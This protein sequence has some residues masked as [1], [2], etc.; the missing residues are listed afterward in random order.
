M[1]QN[2]GSAEYR[3]EADT[4]D[5]IKNM[6]A[7]VAATKGM[8]SEF[9]KADRDLKSF[10][11]SI[12]SM[13]NRVTQS[14]KVINAFGTENKKLT[15]ELKKLQ[16]Q[17]E[18]AKSRGI[19][20]LTQ[21]QTKA[22]PQVNKLT[23]AFRVQRGATQQLSFQLQDIAVQAQQGTNAFTILGQQ[24]SQVA[25][26]L[27]PGGA[28]IGALI[29][30]GALI[31]SVLSSGIEE[32][33]ESI[34]DLI[35]KID[36]LGE[37]ERELL[38]IRIESE[39]TSA[40]KA[41]NDAAIQ[42]QVLSANLDRTKETVKDLASESNFLK[43][44]LNNTF[45]EGEAENV[46]EL[47]VELLEQQAA[48]ERNKRRIE[49]LNQSKKELNDTE[50]IAS[51]S[52]KESVKA[53]ESLS[54]SLSGQIAL[55]GKNEREQARIAAT[56]KLGT[57]ATSEQTQA[58]N[59]LIDGYFDL[60]DAADKAIESQK[61]SEQES[62]K[63]LTTI[64]NLEKQLNVASLGY[65]GAGKEAF[66]LAAVQ[67]L[68]SNA[69]DDQKEKTKEL[70]SELYDLT[71]AENAAKKAQRERQQA[72]AALSAVEP[73]I[74]VGFEQGSAMSNL[75]AAFDAQLISEQTYNDRKVEIN[76]NAEDQIRQITEDR[77][78]AQSESN[79][80]LIGTLDALGSSATSAF[81][82][83]ITGGATAVD[84]VNSLARTVLDQAIGAM[85][86]LGIQQI[87]NQVIGQTGAAAATAAAAATGT[88]MATAYAP[89]AALASLASFGSNAAPAAAGITST[90]GLASSLAVSG[91]ERGGVL[92]GGLTEM[93]EGNN[94]EVLKTDN[95]IFAVPGSKGRVFNQEQ[96]SQ[97]GGN[98]EISIVN[99]VNNYSSTAT[100]DTRA[101]QQDDGKILIETIVADIRTGNG[102]VARQLES[103]YPALTRQ[104]Q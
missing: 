41:M 91:L 92:G 7:L 3:V 22:V 73:V 81:S 34:D 61:K 1:T 43:T 18:R 37:K 90:V 94:P 36:E 56:I 52:A 31:G 27:G 45:G 24:G 19:K 99:Q 46:K 93:G 33:E 8:T 62:K 50:R 88:A 67:K 102:P 49:E 38:K 21:E 95:G 35:E 103:A 87:K 75:Q 84:V 104:V 54:K 97:I 96:L 66:Q 6:N 15:D 39:I 40:Y 9:E 47:T 32:A 72:I 68:G 79:E 4:S 89:A 76:R 44:V 86:Q 11:K 48:V 60:K 98:G 12:S 2:V 16:A 69:T 51:E 55:V 80:F 14:G 28:L 101:T 77:F 53:F 63:T 57:G 85:V 70:A 30:V 23:Q 26:I 65:K 29:A 5:A 100:V 83:F 82:S 17:A 58:I 10:E 59:L 13:G 74:G 78:R 71:K 20:Q 25:G 42:T 64:S